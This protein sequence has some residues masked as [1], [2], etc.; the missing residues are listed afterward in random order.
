VTFHK[1]ELWAA[2]HSAL[3][4]GKIKEWQPWKNSSGP[5][6]AAGKQRVSQNAFK[7][8][9]RSKERAENREYR[10]TK[11]LIDAMLLELKCKC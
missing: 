5:K 11:R 9:L 6:S 1:R 4:K 7:G 2:N 8:G 10:K 3:M